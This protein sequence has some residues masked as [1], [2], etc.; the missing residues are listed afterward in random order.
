M[1]GPAAPVVT[2]DPSGRESWC[3]QEMLLMREVMK[4]IGKSLSP[5]VVCR[6]MLHLCSELLGLNRGRILLADRLEQL[7][8]QNS[9][10]MPAIASASIRYSYGLTREQVGRGRFRPGEGIT[11]TVLATGQF[12]IV[13][14]IDDEPV[15]LA[16]TVRRAD[17][18][19]GP[20]SF[21]ALPIRIERATVGVLACHRLRNRSRPLA[22]DL[23]LL[24]ILATL[25]GQ[26]LALQLGVEQR[27]RKLEAQNLALLQALEAG[28]ARVT[29]PA[30][31]PDAIREYLPVRSHG[32]QDLHDALEEHAGN[33]SRAAQSLGLTLRQFN[34]RLEK[35]AR[36]A[37]A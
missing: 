25:I 35:L 33:H 31:E 29:G 13:Q 5:E 4:H 19:A 12:M 7:F 11:G 16:R 1:E 23:A 27:T 10:G 3:T 32:L 2:H 9:A 30:R 14:D 34:Y 22:D 36:N 28:Q 37:G 17:L 15:F 21:L 20:V 8:D 24:D 6:E 26:L 18:P